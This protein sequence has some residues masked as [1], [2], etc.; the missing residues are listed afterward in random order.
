MVLIM[1]TIYWSPL[2]HSRTW[3]PSRSRTLAWAF[4][5]TTSNTSPVMLYCKD[6]I[7]WL[8]GKKKQTNKKKKPRKMFTLV[9]FRKSMS[10]WFIRVKGQSRG[11]Q[12]R[13]SERRDQVVSDEGATLS[14]YRKLGRDFICPTRQSKPS[15][16]CA[17]LPASQARYVTF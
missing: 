1:S 5:A 9:P 7:W 8:K 14:V 3:K 6:L 15:A 17:R 4:P 16:S 10:A 2:T 13:R 12:A 11:A